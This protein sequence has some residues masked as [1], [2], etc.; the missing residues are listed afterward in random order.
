MK[1]ITQR[2]IAVTL[3]LGLGVTLSGCSKEEPSA[4]EVNAVVAE[5]SDL[6]E[7]QADRV[8]P[9][10]AGLYGERKALRKL[11]DDVQDEILVQLKSDS[12]D[13]DSFE[14]VLKQSWSEVEA[15]IPKVAKA[16]AEYHAVLEPE[17]R[18]EFAEKME[19]RRERMKE[20][21]RR[22]FLS[23]SEESHT[24]EDVNGKIAD[25]LDLSV[26]QEKQMLPVM[27]EL[28]GER[29]A[30]RQA[31]LNVYNEVLAQLKSDT[32]DALKLESVLRSSWSVIDERIPIVVQA[33]AEAHAVLIPEQRAEFVE[34]IERRQERRKKR[35]QESRK[36]RRKH[37]WYHWH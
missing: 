37:R 18:G 32:A 15:R 5:R 3:L 8:Q 11:R 14:L 22:R 10:T 36:K 34:K 20:A 4:E 23:F 12:V 30:L 17:R 24:A 29:P 25:W 35:R 26:E 13:K 7:E 31:R 21:H 27:E 33:F 2:I 6:N 16:F 9:V 19:K 1:K 28:Y